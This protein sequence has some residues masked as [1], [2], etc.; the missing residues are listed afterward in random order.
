MHAC[1]QEPANF[2]SSICFLIY[3]PFISFSSSLYR[4][5][6]SAIANTPGMNKTQDFG[7]IKK[8]E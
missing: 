1:M 2:V 6:G 5:R 4:H 7:E 3:W 8:R